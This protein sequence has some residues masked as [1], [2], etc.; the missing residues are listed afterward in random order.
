MIGRLVRLARFRLL[1]MTP[2]GLLRQIDRPGERR[3]AGMVLLS[4]GMA[5]IVI[6]VIAAVALH[7][8]R[9]TAIRDHKNDLERLARVAEEQTRNELTKIQL[10]LSLANIYYQQHKGI[11]PRHDPELN[12]FV[13]QL[14]SISKVPVDIHLVTTKGDLYAA[15]GD[16]TAPLTNVADRDY[17]QAQR[18]PETRGLYIGKPTASR[19]DGHW[20]LPMSYPLSGSPGDILLLSADIDSLS[21]ERHYEAGRPRPNGSI[22]LAHRDGT[23]L[24]RV[25]AQ[26]FVPGS[27]LIQ[28]SVWKIGLKKDLQGVL[29]IEQSLIDGKPR[30]TAFIA[31]Q[32]FPLV[33]MVTAPLEDILVQWHK[34]LGVVVKIGALLTAV[35]LLLAH[36]LILRIRELSVTRDELE[37]MAQ[38]DPLTGLFNR[39]QFWILGAREISRITR[40][41]RPL[42]ALAIDLD[43]FKK[44]ND[45]FGHAA[46]DDA[47]RWFAANLKASLRQSDVAARLGGEEFSVLLPET[48]IDNA[49]RLAE[50]IRLALAATW[51]S[52]GGQTFQITASFG[53][54]GTD[55][56]QT[57]LDHLLAKADL[58]LY[59]AKDGGRN[60]TVVA[61][62]EH[63]DE[64]R[65]AR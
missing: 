32:D 4:T 11:D 37:Q 64:A 46:G 18:D 27:S 13:R 43:H 39:R 59:Q 36:H 45:R 26:P 50:R 9:S 28:S 24:L 61:V 62:G 25:P 16:E 7:Q 23:L 54:A 49:E 17:V 52:S 8:T 22:L 38:T 12:L 40:Y 6:W 21:L 20:V 55:D 19:I 3:A 56:N 29:E 31:F 14:D 2:F 10:F 58:A 63:V 65:H 53:V 60:R 5:I 35:V 44:I 41:D 34:F 51:V 57:T 1:Q 42:S 33:V 48:T 15:G 47:L 30:L